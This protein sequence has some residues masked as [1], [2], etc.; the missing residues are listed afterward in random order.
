[1]L[2]NS[3]AYTHD[4]QRLCNSLLTLPN[5]SLRRYEAALRWGQAKIYPHDHNATSTHLETGGS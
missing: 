4:L 2:Q 3:E 1:M 5:P